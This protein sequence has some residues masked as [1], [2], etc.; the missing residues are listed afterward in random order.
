MTNCFVQ[1]QIDTHVNRQPVEVTHID[2]RCVPM[3]LVRLV[4]LYRPTHLN[5]GMNDLAAW[6]LEQ[7]IDTG[8]V[9]FESPEE[10]R[11]ITRDGLVEAF[12]EEPDNFDAL[13]DKALND[14]LSAKHYIESM[15]KEMA[16]TA[17]WEAV[18]DFEEVLEAA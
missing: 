5:Q 8:S 12:K 15:I 4:D 17:I 7:F 6:H 11:E 18:S 13:Y 10:T 1:N 9:T 3:N 2:T 16:I 14:P